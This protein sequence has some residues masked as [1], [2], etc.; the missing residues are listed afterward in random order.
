MASTPVSATNVTVSGSVGN[1]RGPLYLLT[2]LFFMWGFITCLNDI[3]IP[4][5]KALFE[6]TYTK[7]M[8]IQLTFFGAYA[9]MSLPAGL[10]IG[11]IG[12]KNGIVLGL[13][14]AALGAIAFYPASIF[15]SYGMFLGG[16]FILASGITILQVAANPF[17]AILG[18]PESASGRLNMTQAFNSF[19][20]TIAPVFGGLLIFS[21]TVTTSTEK[22][23]AVQLPYIGIALTLLLVAFVFYKAKLPVIQAGNSVAKAP[24][25]A[26][27]YRHLVLGAVAIFI[28]VGA[29][30]SIGSFLI[31]FFGLSEIA[32]FTES[33]ASKYVS[34]YWGGAMIGR[35][36]GAISLTHF[37]KPQNRYG[38]FAMIFVGAYGLAYF[39]TRDAALSGVFLLLV[40]LNLSGFL[41][42]KNKPNRTLAV[43]AGAAVLLVGLTVA[44]T[45]HFA[46]WPIIAVGLFNSIMF[47]TIFTLAIEDLGPHTSQGSGILCMAI[48][49][50]A[51][52]PFMMGMLADRFGVHHAFLLPMVGYLYILYYGVAGYKKEV[53]E[54]IC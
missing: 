27:Q 3:L 35:F 33:Q 14:V 47:P 51:I 34:L 54:R 37:A 19:G 15:I 42:G 6:L 7:T 46:I 39:L 44:S 10:I 26:W 11:R 12:Y 29:E 1:Y 23:V 31:N 4:H 13:V 16:L 28:Y 17:V 40:A 49:G 52:V 9:I 45:G 18:S 38:L 43:L 53:K 41:L 30:V 50:G 21:D 36:F 20:T 22:A 2:T 24:G 25:S 48:V 5:L 32:G 8:L